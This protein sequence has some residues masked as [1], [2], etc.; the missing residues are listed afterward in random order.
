[1]ND[2]TPNQKDSWIPR[3]QLIVGI[4]L[5]LAAVIFVPIFEDTVEGWIKKIPGIGGANPKILTGLLVAILTSVLFLLRNQMSL[6][7]NAQSALKELETSL[8]EIVRS[9]I[10][11]VLPEIGKGLLRETLVESILQ[12]TVGAAHH[13]QPTLH[14]MKTLQQVDQKLA[15]G[16]AVVAQ[17]HIEGLQNA[18]RALQHETDVFLIRGDYQV[19]IAEA[20]TKDCSTI[21]FFDPKPSVWSDN[22]TN[23]VNDLAKK[24][25]VKKQYIA[26]SK[27]ECESPKHE[28][29]AYI[30]KMQGVG[31]EVFLVPVTFFETAAIQIAKWRLE[32]Y[33]CEVVFKI[34][35]M[36]S[37]K[38]APNED[39]NVTLRTVADDSDVKAIFEILRKYG[40]KK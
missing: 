21:T 28:L 32:I 37:F 5:I 23:Y 25:A 20:F 33:N 7:R 27:E 11:K 10:S 30:Q 40:K 26:C 12:D 34:Q 4:V 14:F 18:L 17:R 9:E 1:M 8:P 19:K 13:H 6:S 22:F 36:A 16:V 31:F 15:P 3:K 38:K 24:T 39:M 35:S 29:A 2:G